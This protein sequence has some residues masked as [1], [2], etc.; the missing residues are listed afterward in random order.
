MVIK[1]SAEWEQLGD[2]WISN[3]DSD[4]KGRIEIKV[5]LE[6]HADSNPST[7]GIGPK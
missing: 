2:I 3:G 5:R 6:T 4:G 7:I 1:D